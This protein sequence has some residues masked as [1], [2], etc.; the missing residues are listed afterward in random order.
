M[1]G[2]CRVACAEGAGASTNPFGQLSGT[3]PALETREAFNAWVVSAPW[4]HTNQ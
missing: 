1:A 2:H 3:V 4:S